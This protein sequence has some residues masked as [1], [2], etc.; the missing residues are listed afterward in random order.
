MGIRSDP[1]TIAY[2][3]KSQQY[4]IFIFLHI[5][6]ETCSLLR[7]IGVGIGCIALLFAFKSYGH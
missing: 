1:N 4:S 6:V 3:S 2:K 7:F 5:T